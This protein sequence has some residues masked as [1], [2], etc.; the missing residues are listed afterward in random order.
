MTTMTKSDQV[1]AHT[2]MTTMTKSDQV[3][4]PHLGFAPQ[5]ALFVAEQLHPDASADLIDDLTASDG[6]KNHVVRAFFYNM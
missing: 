5:E 1:K 4:A 6:L 2:Y 3:K